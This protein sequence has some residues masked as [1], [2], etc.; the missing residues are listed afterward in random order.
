MWHTFHFEEIGQDLE[1]PVFVVGAGIEGKWVKDVY[2]IHFPA[3]FHEQSTASLTWD[4]CSETNPRVR[5]QARYTSL[6]RNGCRLIQ[7]TRNKDVPH[8][9]QS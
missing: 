8:S 3:Y 5:G 9:N 2:G 4:F 7:H 6:C 1:L